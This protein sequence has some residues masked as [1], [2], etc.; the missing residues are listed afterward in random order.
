[1]ST[2]KELLKRREDLEQWMFCKEMSDNFY[3]TSGRYA[4]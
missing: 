2:L 1:M 4:D 3:H